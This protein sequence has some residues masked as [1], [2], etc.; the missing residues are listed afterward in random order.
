MGISLEWPLLSLSVD[1]MLSGLF[2]CVVGWVLSLV[3][4]SVGWMDGWSSV[5]WMV[6]CRVELLLLGVCPVGGLSVFN[7]L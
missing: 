2:G 5:S 7:N 4:W 1:N 3:G 6:D